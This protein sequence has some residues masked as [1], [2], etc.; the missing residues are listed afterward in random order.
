MVHPSYWWLIRYPVHQHAPRPQEELAV[1]LAPGSALP[2]TAQIA[3][4]IE[5]GQEQV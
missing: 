4:Q 3:A 2:S 5:E 1:V